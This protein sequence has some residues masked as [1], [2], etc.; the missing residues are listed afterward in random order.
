[1]GTS[2]HPIFVVI[3]DQDEAMIPFADKYIF[4]L[5]TGGTTWENDTVLHHK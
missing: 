1:M 5:L 3:Q 4:L 2:S